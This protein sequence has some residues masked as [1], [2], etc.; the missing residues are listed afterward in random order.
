ML[1]MMARWS[2]SANGLIVV[3]ILWIGFAGA[4]LISQLYGSRDANVQWDTA[5]EVNTA[6]F[7]LYR[8]TAPDG[9]FILVNK[10][11]ELIPG[12]G[13]ALSGATYKFTD[14]NVVPGQTY[15][16][17]VEEVEYDLTSRR[18]YDEMISYTVPR[19]QWWAIILVAL[20]IFIGSAMLITGWRESRKL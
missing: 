13:S 6:G 15:Y 16:Y 14:E 10:V 9:E 11:G 1:V 4:V 19:M 7:Y 20:G 2:R 3:G 18:Y 17:V 12:Q 8:S 5:T